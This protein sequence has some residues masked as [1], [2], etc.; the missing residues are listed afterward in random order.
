MTRFGIAAY[1][2]PARELVAL[3]AAADRCGFD[4]LW[5]GEHV[6]VPLEVASTHPTAG[7][8]NPLHRHVLAPGTVLHDPWA[9]LGAVA[10]VTS[11]IRLATGVLVLPLHSPLLVA[12]AVATLHALSVGRFLLGVGSGWV[13]EEFAVLDVSF[14]GRGARLDAALEL[15]GD[16]LAGKPVGTPA[17]Q[18]CEAPIEVP[19]VVG[20]SSGPALRRAARVGDGWLSSG[21][22]AVDEVLRG[23][24]VIDTHR[25]ALGRS[26]LPFQCYGRLPVAETSLV[27]RYRSEGIEDVVVWADH[28]WPRGAQQSWE[29]KRTHLQ[30]RAADLGV[31][32]GRAA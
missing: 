15:I 9:V 10:A 17:V 20:G 27:D 12:R 29:Q 3:A 19:L 22:A 31:L 11:R 4:T 16:A 6:G 24:D 21:A 5:V 1:D 14:E 32:S 30:V 7:A 8:V 26:H 2:L 25:A 18:V 28:V 13:A 23:R